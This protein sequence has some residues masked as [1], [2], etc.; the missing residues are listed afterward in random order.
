MDSLHAPASWRSWITLNRQRSAGAFP[1]TTIGFVSFRKLYTTFQVRREEERAARAKADA[2][3]DKRLINEVCGVL[4]SCGCR[5]R[6]YVRFQRARSCVPAGSRPS[7]CWEA[8]AYLHCEEI[9]PYTSVVLGRAGNPKLSEV[10]SLFFQ[11]CFFWS[12]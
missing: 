1:F 4:G 10:T 12:R 3:E 6:P 11:P 5:C 2:N 9:I 7:R 8:S